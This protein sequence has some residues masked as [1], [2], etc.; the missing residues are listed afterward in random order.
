MRSAVRILYLLAA[1]MILLG[2]VGCSEHLA[3]V[4]PYERERLASEKMLFN[5]MGEATD[6]A[7]HIFL[8]REAAEGGESAFQGGCGC[9]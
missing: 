5:P 3:V 2:S 6:Y 4:K 8:I 1:A 9:R 7:T